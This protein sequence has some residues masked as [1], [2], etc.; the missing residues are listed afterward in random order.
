MIELLAKCLSVH[1]GKLLSCIPDQESAVRT[2]G[3]VFLLGWGSSR[4]A[5]QARALPA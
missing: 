3:G 1:N 2:A 5:A 4:G